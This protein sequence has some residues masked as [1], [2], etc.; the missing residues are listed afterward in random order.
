[1]E[2]GHLAKKAFSSFQRGNSDIG[3]PHW[4]L[5]VAQ[6]NFPARNLGVKDQQSKPSAY[7]GQ[8]LSQP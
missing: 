3:V 8:Q 5:E 6:P 1:M 7:I 2:R 4:L